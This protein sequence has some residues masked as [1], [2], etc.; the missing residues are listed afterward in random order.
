MR[1]AKH[2]SP[3]E[4]TRKRLEEKIINCRKAA[5]RA[6]AGG[7]AGIAHNFELQARRAAVALRAPDRE[8]NDPTEEQVTVGICLDCQLFRYWPIN[9]REPVSCGGCG[10][11]LVNIDWVNAASPPPGY[12][13]DQIREFYLRLWETQMSQTWP[14]AH[15]RINLPGEERGR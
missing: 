13:R 12:D 2:K 6:R 15:K 1:K 5:K 14:G 3:I 9:A 4:V 7:A 8:L 10:G 11:P